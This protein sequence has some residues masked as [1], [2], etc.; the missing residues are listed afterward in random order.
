MRHATVIAAAVFAGMVCSG[1]M[2]VEKP[3]LNPGV[4][5][6]Q[7][8]FLDPRTGSYFEL[9]LNRIAHPYW[10][11][12]KELAVEKTYKGRRGRLAVVKDPETLGFIREHFRFNEE[13]WIGL[14]FY[15]KFRK[16]VWVSGEI[17][18]LRN[19][20]MWA[21]AQSGHLAAVVTGTRTPTFPLYRNHRL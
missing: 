18:P 1:A 6:E 7:G 4:P 3:R 5:V 12:A 14:Q 21:P 13:A 8:P 11:L 10:H 20:G 19:P 9:R 16:L 2:A 15:C 17:Q